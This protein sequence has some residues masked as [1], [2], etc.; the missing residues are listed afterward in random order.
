MSGPAPKAQFPGGQAGGKSSARFFRA[1]RLLR[2]ADFERV[3]AE[4]ERHF[5]RQATFF[6]L[7]RAA[8]GARVGFTVSRMLGGSVE[9]NRIRRRMREAVRLEWKRLGM[10]AD[11]VVNPK[12]SVLQTD[13]AEIRQE[14]GRAFHVI[15]KKL[16]NGSGKEKGAP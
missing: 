3:Y 1:A 6:F 15:S 13:F 9:R 14:V 12:R 2:H 10:A 11:I 5:G 7:P 4:G 8:A 16:R